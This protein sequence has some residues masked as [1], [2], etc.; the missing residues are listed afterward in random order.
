MSPGAFRPRGWAQK[1]PATFIEDPDGVWWYFDAVMKLGHQASQRITQHPVQIGANITD[2]SFA[3]PIQLTM[4]IG[5]SDV[6]ASYAPGQ[7]GSDES[8]PTRSVMAYQTLLQWKDEGTPL[9]ITTRLKEYF[10]MVIEY[11]SSDDTIQT[12]NGLRAIV[13]FQQIFTVAIETQKDSDR[14]QVTETNKTGTKQSE[15]KTN[16][17]SVIRQMTK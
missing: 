14:K 6:M 9:K 10:P 7:W 2:H 12:I 5:M 8:E 16:K 3:L 15:T 13:T 11:I 1:P 4:E 17:E